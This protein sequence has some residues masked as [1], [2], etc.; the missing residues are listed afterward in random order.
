MF[1]NVEEA[2]NTVIVLL[3]SEAAS[4]GSQIQVG[5]SSSQFIS[6]VGIERN[7]FV[8]GLQGC[9]SVIVVSRLG[10]LEPVHLCIQGT[11]TE[12]VLMVTNCPKE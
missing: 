6:F 9:T 4:I 8:R 12:C 1:E 2:D 7:N 10:K 5:V 11:H 3:D